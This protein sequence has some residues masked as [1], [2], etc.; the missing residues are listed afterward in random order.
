MYHKTISLLACLAVTCAQAAGLGG[1]VDQLRTP[2]DP[3]RH[4]VRQEI[5][6][7]LADATR[8]GADRNAY[9]RL[10]AELIAQ[11]KT[12]LPRTERLYLIRMLELFGEEAS[13]TALRPLLGD[14]D[15]E[16][17]TSAQRA[18][19][20][21]SGKAGTGELETGLSQGK[22]EDRA[23]YIDQLAYVGDA[24]AVEK[25]E[26]LRQSNDPKIAAA[27]TLALG[28][29]KNKKALPALLKAHQTAAAHDKIF[30]EAALLNIG[31]DADTAN[32]LAKTGASDSIRGNAF[33]QLTA[34]DSKRADT[35]LS[36]VI[37]QP[38]FN[39][40]G[41]FVAHAINHGSA[42]AK[43][44]LIQHLATA[45]LDDQ[46]IIVTAIGTNGWSQYEPQ[47]LA[48][49]PTA[50][51][52]L[53]DAVVDTLG[54]TGSDASFDPIY[55]ALVANPK[56]KTFPIALA[57]L[58]APSADKNLLATV[59]NSNGDIND[60]VAAIK[61]LELRNTPGAAQQLNGIAQTASAP[62]E[63]RL[64]SFRALENIGD[65]KSA[66]VL[67]G[68]IRAND[69]LLN[70]VQLSL[71]RFALNFG[72]PEVIWT[73]I[74]EPAL[75]PTVDRQVQENF[76]LILDAVACQPSL[77][78]LAKVIA[79]P[80]SELHAAA[81]ST[82]KRWPDYTACSIWID[83][84]AAPNASADDI[85]NAQAAL[86]RTFKANDAKTENQRIKLA[87]QAIQQGPNAAFK[88]AILSC[89][90]NANAKL[91]QKLK[92]MFKPLAN[93]PDVGALVKTY[94]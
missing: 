13:V 30:I 72:A 29:L 38:D 17:R 89:Y 77:D 70:P 84:A 23:A 46:L 82:L 61:V 73:E 62:K 28:K 55:Q 12:P 34:L 94:L 85:A 2:A 22:A 15:K 79:T 35:M 49:A 20:G 44:Q 53:L 71:K 68:L 58:R 74:Y 87:V 39:A 36:A 14:E 10:E 24:A 37:T 21:I 59:A 32:L 3:A 93:D 86:V 1:L 43:T 27:A 83:I 64:A 4:E 80:T 8:P 54:K 88:Q 40:R 33:Q 65:L 47:V 56:N 51:G 91:R 26:K 7:L 63:L 76:L 11:L 60:R 48:L 18:L 9:L 69:P 45:P 19:A 92:P 90:E 75:R 42:A 78:A 50:Q 67:A 5:L 16:V 52:E 81:I 6:L 57:R 31:V 41:L 25:I 66:H